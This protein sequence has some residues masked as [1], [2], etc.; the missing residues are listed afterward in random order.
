ML[1]GGMPMIA[2][3]P[4][5]L[6]DAAKG[7][8]AFRLPLRREVHQRLLEVCEAKQITITR[9]VNNTLEW[10]LA[11]DGELQSMIFNQIA[12]SPDLIQTVTSCNKLRRANLFPTLPRMFPILTPCQVEVKLGVVGVGRVITQQPPKL[13]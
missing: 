10:L 5:P 8:V 13:S 2:E 1:V 11:Q 9:A 3:M 12:R 6:P 4:K 7:L